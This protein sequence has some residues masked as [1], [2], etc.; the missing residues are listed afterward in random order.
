[1]E[2]GGGGGGEEGRRVGRAEKVGEEEEGEEEGQGRRRGG[3]GGRCVT[4]LPVLLQQVWPM[5]GG[6]RLGRHQYNS[7]ITLSF[8]D[9]GLCRAR[10]YLCQKTQIFFLSFYFKSLFQ[11]TEYDNQL[12]ESERCSLRICSK[13]STCTDRNIVVVIHAMRY[14]S[15]AISNMIKKVEPFLILSQLLLHAFPSRQMEIQIEKE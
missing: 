2:A 1:M 5:G 13:S 7:I 3:G 10:T 14:I 12:V 8:T 4:G 11:V 15:N 9:S 6:G